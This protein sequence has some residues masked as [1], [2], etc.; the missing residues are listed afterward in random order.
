METHKPTYIM[1]LHL[2]VEVFSDVITKVCEKLNGVKWSFLPEGDDDYVFITW[3]I[4]PNTD[5]LWTKSRYAPQFVNFYTEKVLKM[6]EE[7]VSK[8]LEATRR[9]WLSSTIPKV[10]DSGSFGTVEN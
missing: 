2:N 9:N 8:Q 1:I 4:I 7:E 6:V 3:H 5:V 10:V